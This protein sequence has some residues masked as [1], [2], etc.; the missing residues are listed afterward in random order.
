MSRRVRLRFVKGLEVEFMDRERAVRRVEEIGERG[1]Y[2]VYL[3]YGPEGCGK[4]ALLLQA[5]SILEEDF[6]LSRCLR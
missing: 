6:R 1:T 3:V 5:R 4:T 2:P